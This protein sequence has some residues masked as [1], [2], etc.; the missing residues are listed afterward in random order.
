[1]F[2]D[3]LHVAAGTRRRA[4]G[5]SDHDDR[6]NLKRGGRKAC[7]AYILILLREEKRCENVLATWTDEAGASS[8]ATN[9]VA[10]T[11][12][13][14]GAATSAA[15]A[16]AGRHAASASHANRADHLRCGSM[17]QKPSSTRE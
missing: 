8:R 11:A 4:G 16:N 2:D 3:R 15:A 5:P 10:A 9:P 6:K 1:M 14:A 13:I 12:S 7:V 17:S